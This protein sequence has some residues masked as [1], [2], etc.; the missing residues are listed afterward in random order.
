MGEIYHFQQAI[1][2]FGLVFVHF[3]KSTLKH[4]H[5]KAPPPIFWQCQDFKRPWS[6]HLSFYRVSTISLNPFTFPT[7]IK[8]SHFFNPT[9]Q[10]AESIRR[11]CAEEKYDRWSVWLSPS[12]TSKGSCWHSRGN[13][14]CF[15]SWVFKSHQA[16]HCVY[17]NLCFYAMFSAQP[18][19]EP[20]SKVNA[21]AK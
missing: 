1:I 5:R 18:Q 9:E 14:L 13:E 3:V 2:T 6:N 17:I 10:Y 16:P 12:I 8:L 7:V 19:N 4:W 20:P 21:K 15:H 11:T